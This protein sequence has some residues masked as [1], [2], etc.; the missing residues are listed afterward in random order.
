MQYL[1][2]YKEDETVYFL[3]STNESAGASVT[4]TVDGTVSVY[5]DNGVS[6]SVAG[7]TDTEDFDS[8][9]G[10]HA[11]TIDL[12]ADA[13]YATG[14]DYAV[15]L[16]AATIDGQTV[17]AVLAHFSIENR[18]T[19]VIKIS[20][21]STA[22][23][24]VES[25]FLG[26]GHT[27]DV[28]L[29]ARKLKLD[30][31]TD[32]ALEV[33]SSD[34][35]AIKAVSTATDKDAMELTGNGTGAGL[36]AIGGAGTSFGIKAVGATVGIYA[37]GD[38]AL[39]LN[40]T[41]NGL[42]ATAS[43]G[44]GIKAVGS[45][46]DID[47]D[48]HGTID[49][50]TTNT[51]MRGTD[52]AA[53]E[54]K[55]D[56]IDTVVDAIKAITDLLP[57]ALIILSG[58]SFRGTV[59]AADP[60]VSFTISTLAGIGAGAF[61]DANSPWYAYVL[62]DAG[63]AAAA[64]QGEQEKVTGY[65]TA[66]GLFTTDAFSEDVAVGDDIVIMSNKVASI[67]DIVADTNELQTDWADGGRLDLLIDALLARLSATRAGYLDNLS[68]GAVAL[69]ATLT[70]I[71]GAGWT[72]ET[73]KAIKDAI[74]TAQADLDS[75]DQYKA[76]LSNLDVAVSTR[77]S[78]SAADVW[79]VA[80]RALTDKTD[81][82]LSTAGTQAI[83]DKLTSA[84]TTVGSVG[85]LL[86]DDI[87]ATI[88]S[89][90][91]HA[92]ADIWSVATR[93]LTDKAGFTIS[94]TKTTLDDLNDI[95]AASVWAVGTRT[96]TGFG[97]L[98][99]DIWDELQAGHATVGSFGKYLDTEVS[100]VVGGGTPAT[101]ADAVWDELK[102][103]HTTSGSFGALIALEATL[104]DI[105]GSGFDTTE[106]SLRVIRQYIDELESGTKPP[107]KANFSV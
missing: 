16:S 22:A 106:D 15:V 26:T 47:A 96:L 6:Q 1:G 88:S 74:D 2:D 51:D 99:S 11:C 29:S 32:V 91:S 66:T 86:V 72:T 58:V 70:A 73:L 71:K 45:T 65:T 55:Q 104:T 5:K 78:H 7:V 50:C 20:G 56:I 67:E 82:A 80:T 31:D 9:T 64:P 36:H 75:P 85:K 37:E 25:V 98:V 87:D 27:D 76:D 39:Y 105:Q 81:F 17:N 57:A 60:G 30:C 83:W 94:G 62:R 90:S 100:G 12:S 14:A 102:S 92:A 84:L 69:E 97:T 23:N 48:I 77:S 79:A 35:S 52:N 8:L 43:D 21:S 46:Y 42:Y 49:T 34:D 54:A 13:F 44:E 4:R 28:D 103:G 24:N 40:G 107:G 3:W 93:A 59:T 95:A 53:T 19:D 101:I 89:R 61:V 41:T 63:G 10:I 18:F 68:A 38:Y 33:L